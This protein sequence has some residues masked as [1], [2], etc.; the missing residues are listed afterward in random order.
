MLNL[1]VGRR[2]FMRGQAVLTCCQPCS[3][4]RRDTR[5]GM[6]SKKKRKIAKRV[7][8]LFFLTSFLLEDTPTDD[9]RVRLDVA[10]GGKQLMAVGVAR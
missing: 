2:G 7:T 9:G 10:G 8:T 5:S 6:S 4:A 1:G 3:L